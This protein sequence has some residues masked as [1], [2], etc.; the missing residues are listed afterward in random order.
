MKRHLLMTSAMVALAAWL[1]SPGEGIAQDTSTTG[2]AVAP[3]D[4]VDVQAL[5][6]RTIQNAAG[7]TVG[8]I[9]NV[10]IDEDGRVEYV[11]VGVGGFLG[12]GEKQVALAWDELAVADNGETVVTAVTK[13]QLEALPQHELPPATERGTVYSYDNDQPTSPGERTT[14][15]NVA[16][17]IPASELVGAAVVNP[18]GE[19]IGEVNEIMLGDNGM[20][21]GLVLDVGG[22]LGVGERRVLVNWTDL[23]IQRTENGAMTV[24]TVLDKARLESLPEYDVRAVQ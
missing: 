17:G 11:V 5:I 22:F 12:V 14:A 24:A 7:E 2:A 15:L 18:Q 13:E 1:A 19:S 6:G 21:E 16:A 20:A 10:I 23:T 9:E 4:A 3:A 8:E